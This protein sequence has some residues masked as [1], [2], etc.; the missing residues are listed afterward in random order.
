MLGAGASY[1]AIP[2]VEGFAKEIGVFADI[3]ENEIGLPNE[4]FSG[5]NK[6][7]R[8]SQK[9]VQDILIDNLR[10]LSVEIQDHASVDTY[11]KVL[12]LSGEIELFRKVKGLIDAFLTG[13]QYLNGVDK[14]YDLFLASI[15]QGGSTSEIE[16]PENINILSWNYDFQIE[17]S[18]SRFFGFSNLEIAHRHLNI[19]P[20]GKNATSIEGFN[21]VKLNGTASGYSLTN[22]EFQRAPFG[23]EGFGHKLTDEMKMSLMEYI[24]ANYYWFTQDNA[25]SS[26]SILFAWENDEISQNIRSKAKQVCEKTTHLIIIGYSFPTFNRDI[27]RQLLKSMKNLQQVY[28]Q[29]PENDIE[30]VE[31]R[32][33][34]LIETNP[35]SSYK[36]GLI[37]DTKEF[38]IPFEYN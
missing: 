32:F 33:K 20:S 11:A 12:Y 38:F 19:I 37:T 10:T 4:Q 30:G 27:D 15:L 8:I 26:P 7:I 9:E 6:K 36:I 23:L 13:H 24:A 1:N 17:L 28:I 3:L 35:N 29:C 18:A 22:G 25:Q 31:T 14:R 16:L 34:A 5:F 2:V 21:M